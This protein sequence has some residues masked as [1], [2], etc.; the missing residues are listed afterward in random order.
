MKVILYITYAAVIFVMAAATVVEKME[1]TPYVLQYWYGSWWFSLLWALLVAAGIVWLVKRHVRHWAT[2]LLHASFVVILLG[3]L[4]THLTGER[5]VVHLRSKATVDWYFVMRHDGQAEQRTFP[6]SI[7]L[8]DFRVKYYD[9]TQTVSDYESDITVIRGEKETAGHIAMN[10]I[11]RYGRYRF[12]QSSFDADGRGSILSINSDPWGIPVTYT[13]Y[14]LLFFSL[15]WMLID[16]R[17]AFRRLLRSD[18]L[19]RGLGVALLL[20]GWGTA[21]AAPVIPR[22]SAS[23]MGMLNVEYNGRICPLQTLAYD[24]SRKLYGRS[25]PGGYTPEQAFTGFIFWGEEWS[26]EPMKQSKRAEQQQQLIMLL[27]QGQ[28][29]KLFPYTSD[30]KTIWYGPTDALPES[31]PRGQRLF[32]EN[33]FVMLYEDALVGDWAD[34]DMLVGKMNGYQQKYGGTSLPSPTQVKAERL[35]NHIPF[36]TILF[37]FNL[38]LGFLSLFLVVWQVLRRRSLP[39]AFPVTLLWLLLLSFLALTL[40]LSLRWL[41]SGTIPLGNGYE[42]ML[43]VA[44]LVQLI[45][46]LSAVHFALRRSS[47]ALLLT[48]FGFLLSGFFLLVSH[49]NSMDPAIGRL[50]PVLQSPLLSIHVSIIMTSYALLSLTCVCG[51]TALI[52]AGIYRWTKRGDDEALQSQLEALQ[53]LSRIFLYP[54][55]STMGLG[56]FIGA[57]WANVSWGNYWSWDPKETWALITFM[58]YAVAIHGQSLPAFRRPLFYHVYMVFAFLTLIITYFGVNYFLGGMHSYA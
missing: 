55:L 42:T 2:W 30:G 25:V 24:F 35:Y 51:L 9:G 23:A 53:V 48:T 8:D 45:T 54:A 10:H 21:S 6:F 16:P 41:I 43:A 46:L 49:I 7:R 26:A 40:C 56:I 37:M 50:M 22:A 20:A 3:A 5:G 33:V 31:M 1:G 32:I 39:I 14:A 4:L 12:Y 13:G 34:F 19:R 29:L 57:I 36:A 18:V 15:I 38:T 58:V 17:M 47:L 11:F 27:R 44:W 28:L 52:L